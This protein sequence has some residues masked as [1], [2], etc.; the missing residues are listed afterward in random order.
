[1]AGSV[2]MASLVDG[3]ARNVDDGGARNVE[4]DAKDS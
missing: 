1:M 3:A 2:S 4:G